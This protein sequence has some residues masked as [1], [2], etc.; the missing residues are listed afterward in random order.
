M[1]TTENYPPGKIMYDSGT[2]EVWKTDAEGIRTDLGQLSKNLTTEEAR[3][4]ADKKLPQ[5][6]YKDDQ[7]IDTSAFNKQ[8]V[9][10]RTYQ[11]VDP[12]PDE[13]DAIMVEHEHLIFIRENSDECAEWEIY[14]S[15]YLIG[16][17]TTGELLFVVVRTETIGA[18]SYIDENGKI[19]GGGTGHSHLVICPADAEATLREDLIKWQNDL[20]DKW[21]REQNAHRGSP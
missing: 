11:I 12:L 16:H 9:P 1:S 18:Y 7:L 8:A 15:P 6:W 4:L 20:V 19:D 3:I 10:D 17:N 14:V 5:K 13:V 21:I 2:G